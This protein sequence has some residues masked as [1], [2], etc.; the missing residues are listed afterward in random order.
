MPNESCEDRIDAEMH[1]TFSD[2]QE[3]WDLYCDDSDAYHEDLGRLDE[4][5]LA[6][7]YVHPGTFGDEQTEGYW[8]YQLSWGGPSDEFRFYLSSDPWQAG[9]IIYRFMDWGDGASRDVTDVPLIRELWDSYLS[10][11]TEGMTPDAL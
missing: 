6:F 10:P 7:D 3:L 9:R 1:R 2:L 4:Y 5:A 11:C 8:R